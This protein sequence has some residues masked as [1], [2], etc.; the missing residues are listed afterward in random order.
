MSTIIFII[1]HGNR[2]QCQCTNPSYAQTNFSS[3]PPPSTS[4]WKYFLFPFTPRFLCKLLFVVAPAQWSR[5]SNFLSH[6]TNWRTLINF[7]KLP[8]PITF[9][10]HHWHKTCTTLNTFEIMAHFHCWM[11][12]LSNRV[13]PILCIMCIITTKWHPTR[14]VTVMAVAV[15]HFTGLFKWSPIP[16][17]VTLPSPSQLS[18]HPDW[19]IKKTVHHMVATV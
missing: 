18:L 4:S 2:V 19:D 15:Q 3:E 12:L 16:I 17:I 13:K 14:F 11:W 7:A 6:L 1:R 8:W 5:S 10:T 9:Y